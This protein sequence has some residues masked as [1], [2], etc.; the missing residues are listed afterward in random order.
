VHRLW[1]WLLSRGSAQVLLVG[2]LFSLVYLWAARAQIFDAHTP[3]NHFALLAEAFLDGRLDLRDGPPA[4]AQGNDFAQFQ[5]AWYVVFPPLPAL[6]IL[7]LVALSGGAEQVKDGLFFVSLAGLAPALLYGFLL[8]LEE[9]NRMRRSLGLRLLLTLGYG[10]GTVYFFTAVEGTVWFAAHVVAAIATLSFLWLA[11]EARHPLW[12]G[13]LLAACLATRTHLLAYG[14]FFVFEA[15]WAARREA[16]E[17]GYVRLLRELPRR[18]VPFLVPV[19]LTLALLAW[20]NQA[21]FGDPTEVGYRYLKIAWR[22]RIEKWG[23]FDYHYLARNLGVL[24]SGLPYLTERGP[25]PFQINGH[26]LGLFVTTPLYLLLFW[27]TRRTSP[28]CAGLLTTLVLVALPSLFYQNTGWIQF[29]QRFSNDYAPL[30]FTM[31]AV[32][33]LKFRAVPVVLTLVGIAI[34]TFGALTFGRP[35]YRAYYFIEPSQRVIYQPD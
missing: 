15:V 24:L 26:G 12:A 6:L 7:P 32:S 35:E 29:G 3:F 33:G 14:A 9:L 5:G 4:Y 22:A 17:A 1:L 18:L 30:L 27:K 28:L 34:N 19:L 20:Y 23:L 31:L 11:L 10:F 8:R 13:L 21:R 25:V 2:A 16:G